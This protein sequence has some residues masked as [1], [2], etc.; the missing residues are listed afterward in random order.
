M[1]RHSMLVRQHKLKMGVWQRFRVLGERCC[2]DHSVGKR[3][4]EIGVTSSSG[5]VTSKLTS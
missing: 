3:S 4:V 2:W 1:P 5:S